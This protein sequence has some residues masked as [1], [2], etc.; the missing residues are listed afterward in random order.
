M[1]PSCQ[2]TSQP[3]SNSSGGCGAG[4]GA[5]VSVGG[6]VAAAVSGVRSAGDALS[7]LSAVVE[8]IVATLS[9]AFTRAVSSPNVSTESGDVFEVG[10]ISARGCGLGVGATGSG[11]WSAVCGNVSS[12]AL[13]GPELSSLTIVRVLPDLREREL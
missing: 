2:Q 12:G 7:A 4:A 3:I 1:P 10:G 5:D 13:A 8:D 11:A 9:A 6:G